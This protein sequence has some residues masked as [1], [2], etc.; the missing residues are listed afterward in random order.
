MPTPTMKTLVAST[1]IQAPLVR[2][3]VKQLGGWDE[4]TR[5]TMEDIARYGV[6]GGFSGF[7]YYTDT[8]AFFN[9]NKNNI[10]ALAE[11]Q[12]REFGTGMLEMVMG[13]RCIMNLDVTPDN[14]AR[15]LYSG[16]GDCADQIKNCMAWYAAE[17]VARA[18]VDMLED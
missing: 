4:D 18:Y 5:L 11:S 10:L 12:A 3:V 13:F 1:N 14:V 15:V 16:R 6:D 17:E 2:A 7:I 9:R 8:V